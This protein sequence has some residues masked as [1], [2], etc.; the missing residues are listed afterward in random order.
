M[1]GKFFRILSLTVIVCILL[2]MASFAASQESM[3]QPRWTYIS[4]IGT[5]LDISLSGKATC[6]TSVALYSSPSCT[7]TIEMI[8]QQSDGS[9]WSDIKTWT[10]SGGRN[11]DIEKSWYI[12]SGY[13][14]QVESTTYVYNSDGDLVETAVTYSP[15]DSF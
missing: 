5:G 15:I 7:C 6:Y 12:E 13:E 9:G 4:E 8:L 14:Y 2:S 10:G 1:K 11:T 3:I